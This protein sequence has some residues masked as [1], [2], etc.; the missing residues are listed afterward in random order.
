MDIAQN[1]SSVLASSFAQ[2]GN[3]F[4]AMTDA[5]LE[6]FKN[7]LVQMAAE[8]AANAVVFG[9]LN[10]FSGGAATTFAKGFTGLSGLLLG[11][12][13][14]GSVSGGEASIIGE[15]RAE[16]FVP[17]G[18]GLIDPTAG[19]TGPGIT[20]IVRNPAEAQSTARALRKD[21]RQRNTGLY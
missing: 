19:A 11:H 20:I 15:R 1:T 13:T 16:V 4:T 21:A 2:I 5:M 12:A 17:R 7:M 10:L 14:G 6:G 9:I 18:P 8:L 3:G